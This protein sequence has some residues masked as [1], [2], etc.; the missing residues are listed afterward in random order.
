MTDKS[1]KHVNN[2]PGLSTQFREETVATLTEKINEMFPDL[3]KVKIAFNQVDERIAPIAVDLFD[4]GASIVVADPDPANVNALNKILFERSGS[5]FRYKAVSFNAVHLEKVDL[6][7]KLVEPVEG[8]EINAK[9]TI[10]L[11]RKPSAP[12]GGTVE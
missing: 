10:S 1:V 11:I 9:E 2:V 7:I 12:S 4:K 3:T 6:F 5:M 8:A